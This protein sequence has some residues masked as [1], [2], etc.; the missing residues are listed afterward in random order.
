MASIFPAEARARMVD[1]IAES[2]FQ[3]LGLKEALEKERRA[4]E[5]QNMDALNAVVDSKATYVERL[6]KLDQERDDLCE[7]W[8]FTKGP[9]QMT[10]LIEWCDEDALIS[11]AWEQLLTVAAEGSALN[12]TNGA[13]IRVR[14]QHFE[15]SLSILRGDTP[16]SDT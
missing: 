12:I 8:G 9:H 10:A 14:Q 1:L 3:A 2:V 4:L 5:A 13:I 15:S 11:A 6:Q 16:G 7:Q